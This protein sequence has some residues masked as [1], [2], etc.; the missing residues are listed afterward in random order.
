[1]RI[2]ISLVY[3]SYPVDRINTRVIYRLYVPDIFVKNMM[4]L[5]LFAGRTVHVHVFSNIFVLN[6]TE[7]RLPQKNKESPCGVIWLP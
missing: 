7:S 5:S 6:I 3:R 1:M 4:S 2:D